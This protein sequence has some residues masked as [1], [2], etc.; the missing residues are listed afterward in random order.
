MI[1]TKGITLTPTGSVCINPDCREPLLLELMG[2]P[3]A[4]ACFH[5]APDQFMP[6]YEHPRWRGYEC[7]NCQ[8]MLVVG[9][10]VGRVA[11]LCVDCYAAGTWGDET[12]RCEMPR[13]N[14]FPF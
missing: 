8:R 5:C 10:T 14:P 13:A 2:A 4:D 7:P 9:E 12:F 1:S 6:G 3:N 11:P